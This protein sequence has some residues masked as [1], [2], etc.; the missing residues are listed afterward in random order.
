MQADLANIRSRGALVQAR[1]ALVNHVRSTVKGFG[2]R[3]PKCSTAAFHVRAMEHLPVA[4]RPVLEP[5]L[6]VIAQRVSMLVILAS[7]AGHIIR[8]VALAEGQMYAKVASM[9]GQ[10]EERYLCGP[11]GCR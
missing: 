2:T 10:I 1:A 9:R 4:L 5:V 8:I 3:L 7:E 6:G 11:V